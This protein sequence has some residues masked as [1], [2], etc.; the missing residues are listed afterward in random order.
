MFSVYVLFILYFTNACCKYET[1]SSNLDKF[2]ERQH[3]PVPLILIVVDMISV[4]MT[5][6]CSPS[7][8]TLHPV[9]LL[10][11]VRPAIPMIMRRN[12]EG[13]EHTVRE[14]WRRNWP[15]VMSVMCLYMVLVYTVDPVLSEL[16]LSKYIIL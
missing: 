2:Q 4:M 7:L 16:L 3:H 5:P 6:I 8:T 1:L 13:T 14:K 11:V 15:N 9:T 12:Q 10:Q